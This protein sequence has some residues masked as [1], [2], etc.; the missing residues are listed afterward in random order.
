STLNF[1]LGRDPRPHGG[2]QNLRI[3]CYLRGFKGSRDEPPIE[4]GIALRIGKSN[5]G[6][7][8]IQSKIIRFAIAIIFERDRVARREVILDLIDAQKTRFVDGIIKWF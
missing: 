2:S 6:L 8:G 4:E 3:N 1:R 7:E 5:R